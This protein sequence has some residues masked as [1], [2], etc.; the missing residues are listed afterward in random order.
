MAWEF[1]RSLR[2]SMCRSREGRQRRTS[3]VPVLVELED[4]RVPAPLE[5]VG[6]NVDV[7]Q[8]P[9]WEAETSLAVDPANSKNAFVVSQT[10]LQPEG[11][12]GLFTAYTTANPG[13][14]TTKVIA[15]GADSLGTFSADPHVAFDDRYSNLFLVYL[16]ANE[17]QQGKASDDAGAQT[18]Q[19]TTRNWASGQWDNMILRIDS[20]AAQGLVRGIDSNTK[21]TLTL[22]DDWSTAPKA[23]DSYS[24][25]LAAP[26]TREQAAAGGT[27]TA[28]QYGGGFVLPSDPQSGDLYLKITDGDG[29]GQVR[30]IKSQDKETGTLEVTEPWSTNPTAGS[31]FVVLQADEGVQSV[32][33][34]QSTDGGQT[35]QFLARPEVGM[36]L[37]SPNLATGPKAK[38]APSD[39]SV[40]VTWWASSKSAAGQG[41]RAAGAAV[42]GPGA[43]GTFTAP[44]A[45]TG[46]ARGNPS[47]AVGPEGQVVVAY[48][49]APYV[50]GLGIPSQIY[51]KTDPDGLGPKGLGDE[52]SI[53]SSWVSQ[54]AI[55]A[56]PSRPVTLQPKLAWDLS[57]KINGGRDGRLY[58]VYDYARDADALQNKDIDVHVIYSDDSGA[59]WKGDKQVN[60][61]GDATKNA[62]SQFNSAVAVDPATGYVAFTW[63]DAGDDTDNTRVELYGTVSR[64]GTDG[65]TPFLTPIKMSQGASDVRQYTLG[66]RGS[67]TAAGT[68][69][70][71]N[72]GNQSW[73]KDQLAGLAVTVTRGGKS[74][75]TAII[76]GNDA[77]SFTPKTRLTAATAAGDTYQVLPG[78]LWDYGGF[79]GLVFRDGI[80]QASWADN[81]N[82]TGNNPNK[83]RGLDIYTQQVKVEAWPKLK[84]GRWGLLPN[85]SLDEAAPGVLADD[86]VPDGMAVTVVGATSPAHGTLTL[87]EDGSFTYTPYA[88]FVGTDSF[89]YYLVMEDGVSDTATVWL[90]ISSV[91]AANEDEYTVTHDQALLVD[92]P[93]VLDN[94]TSPEG[95]PLAAVL[96]TDPAHGTLTL[97]DDG[98]F[99]YTPYTGFTGTD[100]FT[101]IAQDATGESSPATV[102][103]TVTNDLAET[104]DDSYATPQD[105]PLNVSA[106]GVL[107]NDWDPDGDTLSAVLETGPA[108]GSLTLNDDG[109]FTYTP[110][111]GFVGTDSFT[112]YAN[113]G[114]TDGNVSTV[115]VRVGDHPPVAAD[116]AYSVHQ[117]QTL[118]VTAPGVLEND[119]DPTGDSLS[120]TWVSSPAHGTLALYRDG[121]FDYTPDAGFVGTDSFTYQAY[122]GDL[123]SEPATVTISV[124]NTPPVAQDDSYAVQ[125]GQALV[126]TDPGVLGNDSDAEGD[127][128]TAVL[129]TAP[130]HGTLTLNDDGSFTYTPYTGFTGTDSFTYTA[131]DGVQSSDPATVTL[132]VSFGGGSIGDHVWSDVDGDGIQDPSEPGLSGVTVHLLDELGNPLSSTTT[133]GTGH[134]RFAGLSAGN[135]IVQ[136]VAPA[137][138]QFSPQGQGTDNT[139][140]SDADTPTGQ[141]A[142]LTLSA[143]QARADVDA[144]LFAIGSGGSIGDFVWE[145]ANGN[146]IQDPGEPGL[147]GATVNLLDGL[148][149]WLSSTATD[150][151]G[152]YQFTG[153][154]AG[155]YIVQFVAPAGSQF[156]P[157]DQGTDDTRDSDA[158]PA[159]G[160]IAVLILHQNQVRAD[161]DAGLFFADSGGSGG[162][163]GFA[164][165]LTLA[166]VHGLLAEAAGGVPGPRRELGV[167]S[168]V[169]PG[170]AARG[171]AARP[172]QP[173]PASSPSSAGRALA[174]TDS[175][176]LGPAGRDGPGLPGSDW[177]PEG[178]D[179]LFVLLAEGRGQRDQLG[180]LA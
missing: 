68:D 173:A 134:Y 69:T 43:F 47:I 135:Y 144:G 78:Y 71:L 126:V 18:F 148:G 164:P 94:D 166:D 72:D 59:T 91:P 145:D 121:S 170:P 96:E 147:Y 125:Q 162:S 167:T 127:S 105:T 12:H 22:G 42:T 117:G 54:V 161:V 33:V 50:V 27:D 116:G 115:A 137:G 15:T 14:W 21:D 133:D 171:A 44:Q 45:V 13:G 82:A 140:D 163:G 150:P 65:A 73:G 98:S 38:D 103:I 70:V 36:G 160:R 106:D 128:L 153:L 159:T 114:F 113:D 31:Q 130:A 2:R 151:S 20:G 8:M 107:G 179:A 139:L 53:A 51:V 1:I 23:G 29:K 86:D 100:S 39:R 67:A 146:G 40:W 35:F 124:T 118:S 177:S 178:L 152:H 112:Y 120:A 37:G 9:G 79:N 83:D 156:S 58:L 99:T 76:A 75:G 25:L 131:G 11:V 136:F 97:D 81:S 5:L 175:L 64:T 46:R 30:K 61:L 102:T 17:A 176:F 119:S 28:L 89:T 80:L 111:A 24:I 129:E 158:D 165:P 7:S 141:T 48:T 104:A 155:K 88:G 26:V 157:K 3:F 4:R 180:W 122:D 143:N 63:Y 101:Y 62:R 41:V 49:T 6:A 85:Q 87:R 172:G 168:F 109:S 57:G 95:N 55:D 123:Y 110:D 138:Y 92:A 66:A 34:D 108:N 142:I 149:N 90:E 84:D 132:N 10:A 32:E 174:F 93:A 56:Q 154:S 169:P 77:T 16:G 52:A 19:D 74:L 60:D